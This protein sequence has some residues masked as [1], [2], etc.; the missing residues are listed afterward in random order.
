MMSNNSE[1]DAEMAEAVSNLKAIVEARNLQISDPQMDLGYDLNSDSG[2]DDL[3]YDLYESA[4]YYRD[5]GRK[6][7]D[8]P[9][10]TIGEPIVNTGF[11]QMHFAAIN[12][13]KEHSPMAPYYHFYEAY[14]Q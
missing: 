6:L 2:E 10:N 9:K 1:M 8:S 5:M 11:N 13:S 7:I 12:R 4:G 3:D 14:K